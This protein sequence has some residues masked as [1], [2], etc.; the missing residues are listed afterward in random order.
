MPRGIV[1]DT[2]NRRLPVSGFATITLWRCLGLRYSTAWL[3]KQK[4][5]QTICEPDD[6]SLQSC[7]VQV[8]D[9]FRG[10]A[11]RGARCE[12]G[13][14]RKTPNAL[15]GIHHVVRSTPL[16]ATLTPLPGGP[17]HDSNWI[18]WFSGLPR[19]CVAHN[20]LLD[21][22]LQSLRIMDNQIIFI[23]MFTT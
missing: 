11:R 17:S 7:A 18:E 22:L 21:C 10:R 4:L 14:A 6:T 2:L 13:A 19:R 3:I 16:G 8:D 12:R 23:I 15:Q 1:A 20:R 5:R 9:E